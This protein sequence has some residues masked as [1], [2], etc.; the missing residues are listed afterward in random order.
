V[1]TGIRPRSS[2]TMK[3]AIDANGVRLT[4]L[5]DFGSTHNFLD[6]EV[7]ERA[8][9]QWGHHAGIHITVANGDRVHSPGCCRN[10]QIAILGEIFI[11]C[12]GLALGSYEMVLGDQ[13]LESLGPILWDFGRWVLQ[14]VRNGH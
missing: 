9:I 10:M 4:A 12:Y 14:F 13:W 6:L 5:L 7:A 8:G 3:L 1:L 11:D 2:R